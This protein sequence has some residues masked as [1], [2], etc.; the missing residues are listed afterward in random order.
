MT[1]RG[2]RVERLL[3]RPP[4]ADF[5]D[6]RA[7]LEDFGWTMARTR[8][9]HH[10]FTHPDRREIF[11]VPVHNHRVKRAYL[12]RLCELLELGDPEE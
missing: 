11:T 2:K 4:E 12:D 1:K 7:V 5:S 3:K 9:S 6:V 8:G 10:S